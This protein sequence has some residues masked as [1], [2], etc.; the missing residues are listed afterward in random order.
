MRKNRAREI[1]EELNNVRKWNSHGIGISAEIL[2]R[3]LNL[4]VD[5]FGA[6]G[7]L[8]EAVQKYHRLLSDYMGKMGQQIVIHTREGYESLK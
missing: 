5:D 6:D 3:E 7:L 2:R 1:A 8:N 4:K